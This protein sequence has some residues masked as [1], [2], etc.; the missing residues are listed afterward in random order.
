MFS[1]Y[2]TNHMAKK[3]K[4]KTTTKTPKPATGKKKD[5]DKAIADAE[6]ELAKLKAQKASEGTTALP[7]QAPAPGGGYSPSFLDER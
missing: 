6:A 1:H 7:P 2:P 4:S 5:L 3:Q